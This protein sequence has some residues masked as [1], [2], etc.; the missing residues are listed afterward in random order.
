[1]KNAFAAFAVLALLSTTASAAQVCDKGANFKPWLAAF[2]KEAVAEG[3]PASV[4]SDALLL[5]ETEPS[6]DTVAG[7]GLLCDKDLHFVQ[8]QAV[9]Y[10]WFGCLVPAQSEADAWIVAGLAGYLAYRYALKAW[11]PAKIKLPDGGDDKT[12]ECASE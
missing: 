8:A 1:M 4:V 11:V 10:Q 3:I 6:P 12:G 7:A 2:K 9:A 5:P